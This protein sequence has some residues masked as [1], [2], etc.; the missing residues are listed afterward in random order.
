MCA[1]NS[2]K[3]RNF[4]IMA[5]FCRFNSHCHWKWLTFAAYVKGLDLNSAHICIAATTG[6]AS[7]LVS[8]GDIPAMSVFS[9][10]VSLKLIKVRA[11][12]D[13]F[14]NCVDNDVCFI[15]DIQC[16]TQDATNLNWSKDRLQS[17][18]NGRIKLSPK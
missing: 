1:M 17:W 15:V 12:T 8:T 7:F 13:S 4:S 16:N 2:P 11:F 6:K 18:Q 5:T 3:T 9:K 10:T 14:C